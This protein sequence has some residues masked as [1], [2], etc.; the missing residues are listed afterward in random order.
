MCS[1][2]L[3]QPS[4]KDLLLMQKRFKAIF[5][6]NAAGIF[7]V[8]ENRDIIMT[9]QRLCDIIGFSKEELLGQNAS[10][11]HISQETYEEFKAYFLK[12]KDAGHSKVEY[13]VK[14]KGCDGIWVEMF[15]SPIE[16]EENHYGVIW[17]VL[18]ISERKEAE[19]IIKNLAFYDSLTGLA[20]RRLFED[21][22]EHVLHLKNRTLTFSAIIFLDLDNF[23]TLNDRFGH[24]L[25]DIFLKEVATRL[26]KC[27]RNTDTVARMG[28]DEFALIIDDLG[29]QKENAQKTTY[30]ISEK[31]L[32]V[33][34]EPYTLTDAEEQKIVHQSSASIGINLFTKG[35]TTYDMILR[36]A[37]KA[38]YQAKNAGKNCIKLFEKVL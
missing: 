31:I 1:E 21:R 13:F 16:L 26:S 25:G 37:D 7:V 28:G 11:A 18:D 23:K 9:N 15:G 4:K 38:M 14:K 27:V 2:V 29:S 34:N 33:L 36:Q 19:A 6:G 10:F 8:D 3:G 5:E 30:E 20:N 22:L 17:S 24:H 32:H 35:D 12:A